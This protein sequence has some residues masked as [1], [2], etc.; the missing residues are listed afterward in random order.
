MPATKRSGSRA[1]SSRPL[2]HAHNDATTG[3]VA[4]EYESQQQAAARWGVSVDTVRRL[5]SDGRVTGYRL[6]ARV[7][8]VRAAEVDACFQPIAVR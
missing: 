5:I 2:A 4:P 8:R 3:S 1:S 6:N 7:I